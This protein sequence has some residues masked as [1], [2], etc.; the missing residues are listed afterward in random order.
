[1]IRSRGCMRMGIGR[2]GLFHCGLCIKDCVSECLE[3]N[4]L[5][6]SGYPRDTLWDIC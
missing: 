5:R 4:T 2:L 1:M 6:I 3:F